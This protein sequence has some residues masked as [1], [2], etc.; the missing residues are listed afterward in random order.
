MTTRAEE[1]EER[2]RLAEEREE[3]IRLAEAR[4]KPRA[5]QWQKIRKEELLSDGWKLAETVGEKI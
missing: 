3:R 2:I 5:D 1:R 4:S